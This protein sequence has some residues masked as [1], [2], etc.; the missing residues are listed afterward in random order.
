[1]RALREL[2]TVPTQRVIGRVLLISLGVINEIKLLA[3]AIIKIIIV[4]V[5]VILRVLTLTLR[6]D[7]KFF[8]LEEI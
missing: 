8:V 1:M 7:F 4:V 3:I 5:V 6:L 2:T